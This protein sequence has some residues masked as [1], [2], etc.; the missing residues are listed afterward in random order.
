MKD[1]M[2]TGKIAEPRLA[3]TI[4]M[5]RPARE[6][7]EILLIQRSSGSRFMAG[8]GAF[9]GG[10]VEPGDADPRFDHGGGI[11]A[12]PLLAPDFDAGANRSFYVAAIRELFEESGVLLA[13]DRD[14]SGLCDNRNI[15]CE[16]LRAEALNGSDFGQTLD[17]LGLRPAFDSLIPY[18][19]WITPEARSL[20]F[21]AFFFLAAAPPGA[22]AVS[23]RRETS[24]AYW[25]TPRQALA[26]QRD[27]T[28]SLSPPTLKIVHEL[29][30]YARFEDL[31]EASK[32][33]DLRPV[34]PVLLKPE[35][36][37]S[38]I[39]PVDPQYEAAR[40]SRKATLGRPAAEGEAVT[41]LTQIGE[42]FCLYRAD[43]ADG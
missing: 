13:C 6:S 30:G 9:P 1:S 37:V 15:D 26:A 43:S 35:G 23:D 32:N 17:R 41:R 21:D 42:Q 33:T 12:A 2:A 27:E 18:A 16:G 25:M 20:R 36:H 34:L 31:M 10:V 8:M 24:K 19:R 40:D 11:D 38:I 7:Y 39:L 22:C 14:S 29:S 28:I 4:I 3:S 5:A